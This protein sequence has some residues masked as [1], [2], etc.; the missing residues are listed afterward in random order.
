MGIGKNPW[1]KVLTGAL[2]IAGLLLRLLLY[3]RNRNLWLDEAMLVRNILDRGPMELLN[4]LDYNQGAPI[5]FLL[6]IKAATAL[7]GSSELSLRLVPL[8]ASLISLPL[9][10]LVSRY[11]LDRRHIPVAVCIFVF[12]R[13]L[14]Y[15]SQEVKQYST[16]VSVALALT[17]LSLRITE[18]NNPRKIE[19]IL[20]SLVG[21][22]AVFL[23]HPAIFVL[24][25]ISTI[26]IILKVSNRLKLSF[27]GLGF[28][29]AI[30]IAS[31]AGNYFL[32]LRPISAND[33]LFAYWNNRFLP[34]PINT[35]AARAWLDIGRHFLSY[36]G[37]R[38]EWQLFVLVL[39]TVDIGV[40]IR[41]KSS[42][43]LMI[44]LYFIFALCA[45]VI[46]KYPF[47]TRLSLYLI[48]FA[49]LLI[50]K[51]LQILFQ[52]KVTI[53]YVILTLFL[54]IPSLYSLQDHIRHPRQRG[55]IK[56]LLLHLY[57][58]RKPGDHVYI[59]SSASHAVKYYRRH[60][61]PETDFFHYGTSSK[62]DRSKY[63]DDIDTMKKWQRV[64][65]LFSLTY[66]NKD[67]E[68]F[69]L[70]HIDGVLIEK[71]QEVGASL[72]LYRFEDQGPNKRTK[73]DN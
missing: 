49:I 13:T 58:H 63:I 9:F 44:S 28:I 62:N 50:V 61:E 47:S 16:D 51:G 54:L 37:Y 41:N 5:L 64:W 73:R 67:E 43:T 57:A 32:F 29:I 18:S 19:M 70:A 26:F 1:F 17:Y 11:F 52:R 21:G 8:L 15:Y 53:I 4:P 33:A 22:I 48:P 55:E 42:S 14:I 7:F 2:L 31:F 24:A 6:L 10:I 46:G 45:S 23:S 39:A 25:G 30:W 3:L 12:S 66:Y 71:R 59:Y 65:F 20:L 27:P 72:Y 40:S 36:M 34:L 56:P 60:D 38:P 35:D 68:A 69:F